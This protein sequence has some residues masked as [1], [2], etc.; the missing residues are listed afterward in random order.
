MKPTNPTPKP[1]ATAQRRA[2]C[3]AGRNATGTDELSGKHTA[4][5]RLPSLQ[6][7]R[8]LRGCTPGFV[9]AD[10]VSKSTDQSFRR[11]CRR[12]KLNPPAGLALPDEVSKS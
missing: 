8:F 3:V 9:I 10:F 7:L 5:I 1:D 2:E 12:R 11:E 6:R 4:P